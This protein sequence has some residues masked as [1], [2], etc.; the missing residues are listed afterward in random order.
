MAESR[1][2]TIFINGKEVANSIKAISAES[3]KLRNELNNMTLGTDAYNKKLAE[4][5]KADNIIKN[6][7]DQ[8][9]GTA[10]IWGQMK[11]EVKQFGIMAM[12][13]LGTGQL[14][15]GID[16]MIQRSAQ[17]DDTFADVRKTT[18]M[19]S[20]EVAELN[21]QLSKID[22]RTGRS[23][24]LGL[25]TIAGKLGIKGVSDVRD[26]VD[27][28]DKINVALGE[29]LGGN[30][31]EVVRQLGTLADLFGE[32]EKYGIGEALNKTGS[33]INDL[34]SA[35]KAKE[36]D[37]VDFTNS[38]GGIAPQANMSIEDILGL[39][40]AISN[41][42]QESDVAS[43]VFSQ[44]LP[45]MF[46][47]TQKYADIAGV[48]LT[49]FKDL[50]AKDSND[51][52][53]LFLEGLNKNNGG[54]EELGSNLDSLGL[55]G[56][57]AVTVLGALSN[58]TKMLR[59]QQD[60][61]NTS[62]ADGI[63]LI[64]EFDVKNNTLAAVLEK[65]QKRISSAFVSSEA[66]EG[67]KNL[68]FWIEKNFDAL[69][70]FGKGILAMVGIWTA[71][72]AVVIGVER[73][74]MLLTVSKKA[75]RT[76]SIALAG[77]Q[78]L[79]AGNTK[80]AA[81]AMRIL[82]ITTAAGPWAI[83]IALIAAAAG[84]I[85]LLKKNYEETVRVSKMLASVRNEA[86]KAI[87]K[88]KAELDNLVSIAKDETISKENRLKAIKRLNEISPL[89]LGN[90]TLENIA[91]EEGTKMLDNYVKALNKAAIAKAAQDK[92]TELY[93]KLIEVEN[94]SLEDNVG[95]LERSY[96]SWKAGSL[97]KD[98]ANA[99]DKENKKTIDE[100]TTAIKEE[101]NA[102]EG[103]IK[104]KIKNGEIEVGGGEESTYT[105]PES[106]AVKE[107][108]KKAKEDA[109]A[110]EKARNEAIKK[111]RENLLIELEKLEIDRLIQDSNDP[112]MEAIKS[113]WDEKIELYKQKFG[114]ETEEIKRLQKLRDQELG[115]LEA[116][117]TAKSEENLK[118]SI[119]K[120]AELQQEAYFLTLDAEERAI[121]ESIKNEEEKNLKI[122]ELLKKRTTAQLEIER[123]AALAS[124]KGLDGEKDLIEQIEAN[125]LQ[126]MQAMNASYN[127][128]VQEQNQAT[129]DKEK[130]SFSELAGAT[131][132]FLGT[133]AGMMNEG[134]AEWKALKVAEATISMFVGMSTALEKGG[135]VGAIE[136]AAVGI[137]GAANISSIL[138]TDIPEVP[139]QYY[140]GGYSM[141]KGGKDGRTYNA[142]QDFSKSGGMVNEASLV[143]GGE[144]GPE[145]WVNDEMLKIPAVAN[146]TNAM[147][148][149]R[150]KKI[151]AV[152]FENIVQTVTVNRQYVNGGYD[153]SASG[154]YTRSN[155]A[156]QY[157]DDKLLREVL[158]EL[159]KPKAAIFDYDYYTKST[160][161]I[162]K[163]QKDA[164]G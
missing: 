84:A 113:K 121:V 67:L 8:L 65:L 98:K 126:K 132:N 2:I 13:Y 131:A 60:L 68:A 4:F 42:G 87:A 153:N 11:T 156:K 92:L 158:E 74:N 118:S 5:K 40:A 95:W 23:E 155:T 133:I 134:T 139:T 76:A 17:L 143:L 59:E 64:T 125:H 75:L 120:L 101:I 127:S 137:M 123:T 89:Y 25:A 144:R 49:E 147:E 57:K 61:A 71:Y 136:A 6:H 85:W 160:D 162:T 100:K 72:K 14:L 116:E 157:S 149:L 150:T 96:I 79:L 99:L 151:S 43:T 112:E 77:A 97:L 21:S 50:L 163:I 48:S 108:R 32:T 33:A 46:N 110:D 37:I 73:A 39:G 55:D 58:N 109:I 28:A 19:T 66:T 70:S 104:T 159:K 78:A 3:R 18:G 15:S 22:T 24:L 44:V 26:F 53:L 38:M 35:S 29:D 54:L 16:N 62:Y 12:A 90:L 93:T 138:N 114:E 56:K 52:L 7:N 69:V 119:A 9:R 146:V 124:V 122:L 88:E 142:K 41:L 161:L 10:G 130:A 51:A 91:T 107:A 154:G 135:V 164:A 117:R 140:T 83:F 80:K 141:V 145:Y 30:V 1:S 115:D 128:A 148:Q 129:T 31:E 103:L 47:D 105:A 27:S 106:D 102:L 63:S 81:T 36:S 86:A 20:E 152:D 82:N 34:G 111:E 45:D 94:S